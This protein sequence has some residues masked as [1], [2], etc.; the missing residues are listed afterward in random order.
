ME[1]NAIVPKEYKR[2]VI[3]RTMKRCLI[4]A[5]VLAAPGLI[6]GLFRRSLLWW[7]LPAAIPLIYLSVRL[8]KLAFWT[9]VMGRIREV[10]LE[11]YEDSGEAATSAQ[12]DFTTRDGGR[13]SV[14]LTVSHWE[15]EADEESKRTWQEQVTELTGK[16]VPIFYH[17]KHP[18][19]FI[20]YIEDVIPCEEESHEHS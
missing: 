18:E 7:C 19:K 10:K 13:R 3:L 20:G 14:S 1:E 5:L 11:I 4:T 17:P 8:Y 6:M 2:K 16:P 9:P 15:G 12:T